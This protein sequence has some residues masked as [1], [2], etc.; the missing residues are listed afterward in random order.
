M[1]HK[2]VSDTWERGSPYEYVAVG[3]GLDKPWP[4]GGQLAYDEV[5][6]MDRF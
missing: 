5:V 6:S 4:R 3:K 1:D 2:H